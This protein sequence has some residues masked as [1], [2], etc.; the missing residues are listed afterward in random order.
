[1]FTIGVISMMAEQE[2][3][4]FKERVISSKRNKILKQGNSYP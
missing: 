3:A 1:M 2:V 4:T